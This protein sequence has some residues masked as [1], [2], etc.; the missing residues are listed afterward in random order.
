MKFFLAFA[1]S[2][3]EGDAGHGAHLLTL[4]LVIMSNAF[5]AFVWI[6]FVNF[7]AH[8]NRVVGALRLANVAID[9]VVG[10]E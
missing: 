5:R 3:I 9:T 4:R 1:P 7:R 2:R 6:D 8:I 10:D